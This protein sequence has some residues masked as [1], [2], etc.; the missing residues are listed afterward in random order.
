M[1]TSKKFS[2]KNENVLFSEI[3]SLSPYSSQIRKV[4]L[5]DGNAMVLSYDRLMRIFE[6]LNN[7]FP[8]LIRISAY[9]LPKDINSK[10]DYQL[11]ELANAGLKLLYT[12]IE[13][14]DNELLKL[15][16]KGE[17]KQSTI[18]GLVAARN[19]GIKLSVMILNGL[20]GKQYSKQHA[21][22]SALVVNE[23]QPEYLSTLV[24]SFPLGLNHYKNKFAGNFI[25]MSKI[26]LIAEMG[27]L[28]KNL[29]LKSTIF[30]SDHASNYLVL[31][32]ILNRD[33]TKLLMKINDVIE[34][35][36]F[37]G[38]RPEWLRGL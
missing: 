20:G 18:E 35:P 1:Y 28:I 2:V 4:F 9:A 27:I 31:K 21:V 15:I 23:V 3:E 5:A 24:L 14:G 29:E 6:K 16:N 38:L 12:G 34:N 8:N 17:T 10:T 36:H 37:S 11:K 30:R 22:N 13:T 7:T 33:K 19:A 32:G 26:D 25:E